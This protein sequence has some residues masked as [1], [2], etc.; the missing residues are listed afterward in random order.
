MEAKLLVYGN[1]L[2]LSPPAGAVGCRKG[3]HFQ[4]LC[5]RK[6]F[7]AK[8]FPHGMCAGHCMQ[9]CNCGL[10]KKCKFKRP[11]VG[12]GA[13]EAIAAM[14]ILSKL[15]STS[16]NASC[17]KRTRNL[18][19]MS[20]REAV[21]RVAHLGHDSG[22][23]FSSDGEYGEQRGGLRSGKS[24]NNAAGSQPGL[25]FDAEDVS[26]AELRA[27]VEIPSHLGGMIGRNHTSWN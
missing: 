2:C 20:K 25:G 8:A 24:G 6:A 27:E 1:G 17:I 4:N 15:H 22:S 5:L 13:F 18:R 21:K 14:S 23:E 19:N 9:I 16:G 12:G 3:W 26:T 10:R 11:R 7:D